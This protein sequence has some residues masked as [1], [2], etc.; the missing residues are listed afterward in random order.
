M[1]PEEAEGVADRSDDDASNGDDDKEVEA[2]HHN[3]DA[4]SGDE[5]DDD[6]SLGEDRDHDPNPDEEEAVCEISDRRAGGEAPAQA[7]WK[8]H[9]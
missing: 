2:D 5:G 4:S 7:K 1:A 8:N 6:P 3:H 9:H